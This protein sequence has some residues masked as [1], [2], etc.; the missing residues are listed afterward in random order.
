MRH[1]NRSCVHIAS[2]LFQT[3]RQTRTG[4]P[5]RSKVHYT[6]FRLY[7]LFGYMVNFWVVP[8][9]IGFYTIKVFGYMFYISVI[10]FK[11]RKREHQNEPCVSKIH[12][13]MAEILILVITTW[14]HTRK[15]STFRELK[16][17]SPIATDS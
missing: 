16:I 6:A 5:R 14:W 13:E 3:P 11:W 1:A 10:W 17:Y 2:G 4:E 15:L 8:N 7:G 12:Q 9:G